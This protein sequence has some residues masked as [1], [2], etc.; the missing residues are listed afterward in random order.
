[1][2]LS[3]GN[4]CLFTILAAYLLINTGYAQNEFDG[5]IRAG[6]QARG[7][8]EEQHE[9][10]GG[11]ELSMARQAEAGIVTA[12]IE[13]R[14]VSE[15]MP[16][17]G[18]VV[19]NAYQSSQVTPRINAQIT[20]RHVRLGNIVKQDQPLVTLSS[21]EMADAQG[22]LIV[23]GQEWNRVRN[24]G[25]EV[26]SGSRFTEAQVA[27]Q[28]AQAR[29]RAFGMSAQ[30]VQALIQQNDVTRANGEFDL[31]APQDGTVISDNFVVGEVV[32]P[33]RVL[34]ELT[35]ESIVW[36]ETSLSPRQAQTIQTGTPA[37]VQAANDWLPG[38][39]I[40]SHHMLNEATRTLSV[41]IE[42]ENPDEQLHPGMF[43]NTRIQGSNMMEGMMV[44][45]E[46]V[47]RS[48]DGDWVVF[49]EEERGYFKPVEV[50]VN[51]TFGGLSAIE[52]IPSGTRV[53]VEGAFFV[54]SEL[55]KSGF[56][57]HN[58]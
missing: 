3:I 25:R 38:K 22:N 34:F 41:R 16:A 1:M 52:G 29:V 49:T 39:V 13:S 27:Y 44:P 26:V 33:G 45:E 21:V 57:I 12:I 9:G 46:A 2:L 11:I 55:A 14:P 30:Q 48:P 51:R 50:K 10:E 36:V 40:Q 35:D 19:I 32:E 15:E 17:P 42:V 43:V 8:E 53:V 31:V 37:Y 54:Q 23:T 47:L 24:L 5:E 7:A 20:A 56:E 58:H 6:E 28:Q 18:E 4:F